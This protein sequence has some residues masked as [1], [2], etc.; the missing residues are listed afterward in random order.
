MHPVRADQQIEPPGCA[1]PE[2]DVDTRVILCDRADRLAV[3]VF[4]IGAGGVVEDAG[5]IG[6]QE[7]H[8][9]DGSARIA[10][11]LGAHRRHSPARR[12]DE[13]HAPRSGVRRPDPVDDPH[14]LGHVPGGTTDIHW[15][16]TAARGG[17][18][19]DHGRVETVAVEPE[20]QGGPG[21]PGAGYEDVPVL[22]HFSCSPVE[23]AVASRPGGSGSRGGTTTARRRCT[24][25]A[26][27]YGRKNRVDTLRYTSFERK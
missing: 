6:S 7:R 1:L 10:E 5:E 20:R 25:T 11:H 8:L 23:A 16:A 15:V 22:H 21:D 24:N 13:R 4:D 19:L 18:T 27:L 17:S 26:Y 14:P 3:H 12:I 9:G 2:S